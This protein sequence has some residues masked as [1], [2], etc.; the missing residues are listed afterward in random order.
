MSF[1]HIK[2]GQ[3]LFITLKNGKAI[4]LED[5]KRDIFLP[6]LNRTGK[7]RAGWPLEEPA[8]TPF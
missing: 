3:V 5:K 2:I 7:Q 1:V 8:G 6:S 4:G